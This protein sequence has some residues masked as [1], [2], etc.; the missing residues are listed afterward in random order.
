MD[1]FRLKNKKRISCFLSLVIIGALAVSGCAGNEQP[2]E[3]ASGFLKHKEHKNYIVENPLKFERFMVDAEGNPLEAEA[4]EGGDFYREYSILKVSGL[5]DKAVEKKINDR[6]AEKFK[7]CV[8]S[9]P[10]YRGIKILLGDE[11]QL[12]NENIYTY[13]SFNCNNVLSVVMERNAGYRN[14][15]DVEKGDDVYFSQTETMNFDLNTGEEIG[16]SE[17]FGDEEAYK[18]L[19]DSVKA[20]LSE[21][22][23]QEEQGEDIYGTLIQTKP[24]ERLD[25]EQKF[26][27]NDSYIN[28]VM[29]YETPEFQTN[30]NSYSISIPWGENIYLTENYFSGSEDIYESDEPLAK[31]LIADV[32]GE[33]KRIYSYENEDGVEMMVRGS[34]RSTTPEFIQEKIEAF[35]ANG[36]Q[37]IDKELK[38]YYR[39]A[40][41]EC[42]R[43]NCYGSCM[44][45]VNVSAFGGYINYEESIYASVT[46]HQ[47][48]WEDTITYFDKN[49][50]TQSVYRKSDSKKMEP[51]DFFKN[52]EDC[53]KLVKEAMVKA[54]QRTFEENSGWISE[55]EAL[56]DYVFGEGENKEKDL[57]FV[58]KM[59]DNISGM[60]LSGTYMS[61]SAENFSKGEEIFRDIYGEDCSFSEN[62]YIFTTGVYCLKYSEIGCENLSIFE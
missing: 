18:Y 61:F 16:F 4:D 59:Y 57:R 51:A 1:I 15:S 7:E 9:L 60:S 17:L 34:Y 29:D 14:E 21:N 40:A 2:G 26:Y 11:K 47:S 36:F 39:Q 41:E 20:F 24:F 27:L 22:N 62:S 8:G 37:G 32:S 45:T 3:A 52:R 44:K 33:E 38:K 56:K 19:N 42:S 58:D 30:M 43:E 35:S 53:E 55:D 28:L 31:C 50:S 6:I 23:A 54:V 48:S 13:Q 46:G 10:A 49:K 25:T 5:K 12:L